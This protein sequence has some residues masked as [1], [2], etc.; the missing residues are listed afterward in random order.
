LK[1]EKHSSNSLKQFSK[2]WFIPTF[3]LVG[4]I[5][6]SFFPNVIEKYY[7]NGLYLITSKIQRKLT[8]FIN[9][10]IGDLFYIFCFLFLLVKLYKLIVI[11]VFKRR[12]IELKKY[13]LSGLRYFFWVYIIFQL[14][15]G[16][17]YYRLGIA[18]QLNIQKKKYTKEEV[19]NMVCDLVSKLNKIRPS[20]SQDSLP[21]PSFNHIIEESIWL[22]DSLKST[23]KLLNYENVSV[24]KSIISKWGHYFG[25]TGYYNPFSGE[26]QLST[27]IP[28]VLAPY[29]VCHEIAHQL[30]YA[31]ED[32]ANF[33]G[34]LACSKSNNPY[35]KYSVYLDLYRYAAVELLRMGE[36]NTHF[37]ELNSLVQQDLRD[38]R[39]FFKMKA[40]KISPIVT[41]VYSQYLKANRQSEGLNSYNDVIG[42][43]ISMKKKDGKI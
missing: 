5:V 8:G 31:P 4:L 18:H 17:N 38:I 6:L 1:E 40:N 25:F 15:W 3:I 41:E 19:E 7:S 35:F 20:I 24:K 23:H 11:C 33:V 34:Y 21:Q 2:N 12:R 16:L 28:T 22:F 14:A 9:F 29:V 27:D 32:E 26:A 10:S 13:L 42:L 37:W 43:L 30:G 39:R 36:S